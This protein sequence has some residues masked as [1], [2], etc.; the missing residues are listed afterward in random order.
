MLDP[1][2]FSSLNTFE[3]V[4]LCAVVIVLTG[5]VAGWMSRW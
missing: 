5:I 3:L 1:I 2:G 4:L